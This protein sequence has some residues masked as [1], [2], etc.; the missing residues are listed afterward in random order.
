M[1]SLKKANFSIK[2][3]FYIGVIFNS[4]NNYA[5]HV[6]MNSVT[7]ASNATK[8]LTSQKN[9]PVVKNAVIL[10]AGKSS[11]F[12][13]SGVLKPKV[14]MKVGGLRLLERSILTLNKAGVDH[15]R[16]VVGAYR[17]QFQTEW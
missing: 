14:L 17:D 13:E 10:A 11:R 6:R 12:R 3:P 2:M 4:E 16:I 7:A 9:Q 1:E 8:N 15:F 5:Q